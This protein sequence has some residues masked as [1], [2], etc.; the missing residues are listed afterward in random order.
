MLVFYVKGSYTL[1]FS[2]AIDLVNLLF[3]GI[4]FWLIW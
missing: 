4:R 2:D 3:D 1:G